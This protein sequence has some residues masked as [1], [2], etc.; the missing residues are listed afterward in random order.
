MHLED[1]GSGQC[2]SLVKILFFFFFEGEFRPTTYLMYL[3]WEVLDCLA[4]IGYY[5]PAYFL[6]FF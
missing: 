6:V 5:L 3:T 4:W 1:K 2:K